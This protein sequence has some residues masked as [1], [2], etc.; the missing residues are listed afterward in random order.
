MQYSVGVPLS[1][2]AQWFRYRRVVRT[3]HS[4][5][6][7][8]SAPLGGLWQ[9]NGVVCWSDAL[10]LVFFYRFVDAAGRKPC[11]TS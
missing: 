1:L 4:S 7:A 2:T 5:V 8:S 6:V 3:N 11:E 9:R 10:T